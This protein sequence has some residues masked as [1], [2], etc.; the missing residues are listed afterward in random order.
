MNNLRKAF[1]VLSNIYS[2]F[3]G[4]S[5]W[6]RISS[7]INRGTLGA[8]LTNV[9]LTNPATWEFS[10]FSQNGEDGITLVLT[11]HILHPNKYFIEIGSSDGIENNTAFFAI[12]KK[13]SGIMV[14]GD[15]HTSYNARRVMDNI[16]LGVKCLNLFV[17]P[18]NTNTI[19]EQ[20]RFS[21]PDIF[22]LDIDGIDYFVLKSLMEQKFR[23]AI[24]IV[25]FN[26]TM[27]PEKAITVDYKPNFNISLE[28]ES[29]LY[30]GVSITGWKKYFNSIG[31]KFVTVESNGVNAFFVDPARFSSSFLN[32]I[33]PIDF[34]ENFFEMNKFEKSN[35]QRF[36]L[37]KHLNFT[38]I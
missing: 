36:D 6:Q 25:E 34:E 8:S 20:A 9:D 29:R 2:N 26:S 32:S 35:I 27:G 12:F 3:S 22:S 38:E 28:H 16:N 17:T 19:L 7:S 10:S 1:N 14:E 5:N 30:Y 24:I 21:N 13:Y 15:F 33:K 4:R 31:Y 23:P 18:E 11:N 37:I